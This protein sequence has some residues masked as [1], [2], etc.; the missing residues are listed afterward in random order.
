MMAALG[1]E[2]SGLD[3]TRVT[4][5]VRLA[6]V[7]TGVVVRFANGLP[8]LV[9]TTIG[10]GR[11]MVF[12]SDLSLQ[13]N[14]L[15]RQPAMVGLMASV[16]RELAGGSAATGRLRAE[17]GDQ[18]RPR[19]VTATS[20]D[21][22]VAINIDP[23]ESQLDVAAPAEVEA[24]VVRSGKQLGISPAAIARDTERAQSWWRVAILVMGMVL[25]IESIVGAARRTVPA[26]G[27]A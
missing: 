7:D 4:R 6:G 10:S 22:R 13:W 14:D 1:D 2:R 12:A 16:V 27:D 8:A 18:Q 26:T 23:A 20:P 3:A 11:L 5:I 24:I 17:T 9:D 25:V 15:P 21:R 19:L